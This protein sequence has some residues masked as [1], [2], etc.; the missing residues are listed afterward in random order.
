[1]HCSTM[2][3]CRVTPV[4]AKTAHTSDMSS[5]EH[6]RWHDFSQHKLHNVSARTAAR[7]S[8]PTPSMQP[9]SQP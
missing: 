7:L 3:K 5:H 8:R 9:S 4:R 6:R 2:D 1:M